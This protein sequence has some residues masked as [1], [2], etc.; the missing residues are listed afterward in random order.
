MEMEYLI[1]KNDSTYYAKNDVTGE[2]TSNT[3]FKTLFQTIID[4][5]GTRD[6]TVFTKIKF[7][8]G[9]FIVNS[10]MTT[11]DKYNIS[12]DGSGIGVTRILAGPTLGNNKIWTFDGS[13]SGTGKNLT[14]NGTIKSKTI[15]M[16]S[17]DASTY[18]AGDMVLLRSNVDFARTV[19]GSSAVSGHQ[20]EIKRISSV[21]GET[22][23]FWEPL[24]DSYA[25]TD[26]ANMIKLLLGKNIS[27]SNF[28]ILPHPSH[29]GTGRWW[30]FRFYDNITVDKVEVV[31]FPG[32]FS[33]YMEFRSC[34]NVKVSNCHLEQNIPYNWQY[35]FTFSGCCQNCVVSNCTAYGD[36]RHAFEAG[37]GEIGTDQEGVCR[38]I[39][40]SNCVASGG[41][42]AMFD[43]HPEAEGVRF[44]NCGVI[45]NNNGNVECLKLRSPRSALIGCWA[46]NI[47]T[48]NDSGAAAI[49]LNDYA[50]D[51]I[52]NSCIVSDA[53]GNGILLGPGRPVTGTVITNCIID[54]STS[55]NIKINT[56]CHNTMISNCVIKNAGIDGIDCVDVDDSMFCNNR[57]VGNTGYGID[58]KSSTCTGNMIHGNWFGNNTSG[59]VHN[60]GQL[61]NVECNNKG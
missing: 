11:N 57:I 27:L 15:T 56:G 24:A 14:S 60:G 13:V 25:T 58:F 9:E 54:N 42:Q 41:T 8:S 48:P 50:N 45:G 26:G 22:I 38:N 6:D 3:D 55:N 35:G 34:L 18:E 49:V 4:T 1:F 16:S 12:I 46:K 32:Q 59:A 33:A 23:T 29:S 20:G 40:F 52:I 47:N 37:N 30:Y 53:N 7:S 2:L 31:D 36:M 19:I 17:S 28:S 43:T 5:I 44:V 10:T 61:G 21:S 39:E 51:C